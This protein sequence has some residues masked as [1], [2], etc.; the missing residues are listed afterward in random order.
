MKIL[1][2]QI[3]NETKHS[4]NQNLNPYKQEVTYD[5]TW[6]DTMHYIFL[7]PKAD[8]SSLICRTEPDKWKN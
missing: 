4:R 7:H 2:L 8:K 6:Y 3:R 5:T 1:K